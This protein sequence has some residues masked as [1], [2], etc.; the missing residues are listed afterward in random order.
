[1]WVHCLVFKHSFQTSFFIV[2]LTLHPSSTLA[3][4][5]SLLRH[6]HLLLPLLVRVFTQIVYVYNLIEIRS[7]MNFSWLECDIKFHD[8]GFQLVYLQYHRKKIL[9]LIPKFLPVLETITVPGFVTF[10][11]VTPRRNR[12]SFSMFPSSIVLSYLAIIIV[13]TG[14]GIQDRTIAVMTFVP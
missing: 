11:P 12:Q 9:L 10:T 14:T 5:M 7:Y 4:L 1:M 3:H 8:D 6:F 13:F 2:I